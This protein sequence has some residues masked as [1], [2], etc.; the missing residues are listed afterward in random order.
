[1]SRSRGSSPAPLPGIRFQFAQPPAGPNR[2][3]QFWTDPFRAFFLLGWLISLAALAVWPL[4]FTGA[5]FR[6][7][8]LS[9]TYLM[10][11]G[12][13]AAFAL[14]FLWTAMPRMLEVPGPSIRWKIAGLLLIAANT[15]LHLAGFFV[16][17]H[18]VF[19]AF[20]GML[21]AFAIHRFPAR[22]DLPPP[23]FLLVGL[24]LFCGFAGTVLVAIGEAGFG[25]A[26]SYQFGRLL[27]TQIFLF[28][29]VMGV[30]AFLAPRFL[31]QRPRQGFP[32]SRTPTAQW[33]KQAALAGLAAAVVL[34]GTGFQAAGMIRTGSL[35]IALSVSA[36]ILGHVAVWR[37]SSGGNCLAMGMRIALICSMAAPWLRFAFPEARVAAA[38]LLLLGGFGLMTL[39][40]G[41]RVTF[42]HSGYEHLFQTR[43]RPVGAMIAL[44]LL[45]L[46]TR[47]AGEIFPDAWT[48]LLFIS[49]STLIA[50]HLLWGI[51]VIPKMLRPRPEEEETPISANHLAIP[52]RRF[53]PF[54]GKVSPGVKRESRAG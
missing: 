9:H 25:T 30:A 35:L 15:T 53:P 46:A 51:I 12:F 20:L 45:S 27:L 7:P 26:F 37:F 16:A 1:M 2:W 6:F 43:L 17:G 24:G 3:Q 40:V 54:S 32:G 14:G 44:Y 36:Y 41:V 21:A 23:S 50:A 19:L 38:H 42:G 28:L 52:A 47:L 33:K 11:Q 49:A 31:G 48:V 18:L 5:I 29:L 34:V 8:A 39:I 13:F 10:I 22:R 4:Y